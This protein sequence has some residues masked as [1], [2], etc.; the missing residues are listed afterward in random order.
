MTD[1][2]VPAFNTFCVQIYVNLRRNLEKNDIIIP[3]VTYFRDFRNCRIFS[4]FKALNAYFHSILGLKC[5]LVTR[6]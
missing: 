1:E 4:N 2:S 5:S 6:I 3:Y